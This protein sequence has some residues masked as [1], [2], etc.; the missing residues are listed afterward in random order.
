MKLSLLTTITL[1]HLFHIHFVCS[2]AIIAK[3]NE[4][5]SVSFLARSHKTSKKPKNWLHKG[6]SRKVNKEKG[7]KKNKTLFKKKENKHNNKP[8]NN[9]NKSKKKRRGLFGRKK[10]KSFKNK[11]SKIDGKHEAD[12]VKDNVSLNL[13]SAD[14]KYSNHSHDD[15]NHD[16]KRDDS[17]RDY[18]H[19]DSDH[20]YKRDGS[21]HNYKHDDS[22]HDYKR[23]DSDHDYK[24]D[25]DSE[26]T[27]NREKNDSYYASNNE[28]N[29]EPPEFKQPKRVIIDKLEKQL[30]KVIETIANAR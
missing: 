19:D 1:I 12:D 24:H 18:K 20:D 14:H 23:D 7:L 17:D 5:E 6:L 4:T 10:S 22:D 21:N 13:S 27:N 29:S 30:L 16:Y 2:K 8:S 26:S 3:N 11:K 28:I 9:G 25:S 15:S